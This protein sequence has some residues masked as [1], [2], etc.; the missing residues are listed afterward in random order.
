M[1]RAIRAAFE[2]HYDPGRD[3][4]DIARLLGAI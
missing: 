4:A 3:A 2:A 1:C